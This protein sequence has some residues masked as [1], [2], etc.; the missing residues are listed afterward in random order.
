MS[1]GQINVQN[2]AT[3]KYLNAQSMIS[4]QSL[5]SCPRYLGTS[6]IKCLFCEL[7]TSSPSCSEQFKNRFTLL[8]LSMLFK[9]FIPSNFRGIFFPTSHGKGAV[10]GVGGE[11]KRQVNYSNRNEDIVKRLL[12]ILSDFDRCA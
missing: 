1:S 4:I 8:S 10:D 11:M 6:V 7:Y 9:T 5:R 12:C 2:K 3:A